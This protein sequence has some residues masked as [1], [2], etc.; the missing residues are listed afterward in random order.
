[1]GKAMLMIIAGLGF[2]FSTRLVNHQK[3]ISEQN[4]IVVEQYEELAA[5]NLATSGMNLAL[6]KIKRDYTWREGYSETSVSSGSFDVQVN[7]MDSLVRITSTG[8]SSGAS[9][10]VQVDVRLTTEAGRYAI[11]STATVDNVIPLDE[12]RNVDSTL[13]IQDA[14]AM[15]LLNLVPLIQ[16]SVSQYQ[17][18]GDPSAII[19]PYDGYPNWSFYKVGNVPNVTYIK[20][21]LK[22]QGGSRIYGIFLVEK[23]IILYGS[24]RVEGVLYLLNPTAKVYYDLTALGGGTPEESSVVGGVLANAN[25]SG[26]GSHISV[27][28]KPEYMELFG[29]IG[30]SKRVMQILT[31]K[32]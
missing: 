11:Y 7:D 6:S 19:K 2:T 8:H 24:A 20:G 22:V 32:D 27:Q 26:T 15:P 28:Y 17:F 16:L 1:M 30:Q 5:K 21:T 31:W 18:F 29:S 9:N 25:V 12:H 3:Q 4:E 23:D 14:D 13:L 10:K